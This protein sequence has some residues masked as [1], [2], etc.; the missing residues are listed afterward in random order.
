MCRLAA[1]FGEPV[2][3]EELILDPEHS[4]IAQSQ[5]ATES[6]IAVNGD[7]YGFAWYAGDGRLGLYRDVL[8]AWG[9]GNL[10]S[11]ASMIS[12]PLILAHVRASTFGAVSRSNCHPFVYQHWSFMHNGQIGDFGRY[13][14]SLEAELSDEYYALRVGNTDSELLFLL[15][16]EF[17][18][19]SDPRRACSKTLE[20]LARVT[21]GSS[22]ASRITAVFSDGSRLYALRTSTDNKSPTLYA[23]RAV[24]GGLVLASEPL[25]K[26]PW[27]PVEEG[28]LFIAD[29][30]NETCERCAA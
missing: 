18:L 25:D 22:K 14:R 5:A 7:G 3:V 27:H 30:D 12:S 21:H 11:L 28:S 2:R 26:A 9:D 8:P 4:L 19:A 17:G 6:K 29:R 20:L 24:N 13:R 1:W 16:L 10:Q 15:L 23:K